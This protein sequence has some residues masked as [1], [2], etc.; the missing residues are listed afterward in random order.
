MAELTDPEVAVLWHLYD[1]GPREPV[2]LFA[3]AAN[4]PPLPFFRGQLS[5]EQ[6]AQG[7]A[8]LID[9]GLARLWSEEALVAEHGRWESE[10]LPKGFGVDLD[11][12]EV[13]WADLTT[14]GWRLALNRWGRERYFTTYDD[15]MPGRIV[16][17]AESPASCMTERDVLTYKID[18]GQF[19]TY[20]M[21]FQPGPVTKVGEIENVRG[22]WYNRFHRIRPGFSATLEYVPA[23]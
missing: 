4:D 12:L 22:W 6:T 16:I 20:G 3:D 9:R 13:G 18:H 15:T 19:Y 5:E 11:D 21:V 2:V 7:L 1:S 8:A 17:Y 10:P 14:E 23:T